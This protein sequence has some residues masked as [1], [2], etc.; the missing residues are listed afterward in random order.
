PDLTLRRGL[1]TFIELFSLVILALS[2][3][4]ADDLLRILFWA[5]FVIL[6]IDIASLAF[7]AFSDS[8]IGFKGIHG[9]KN[10]AGDFASDAFVIFVIGIVYRSVSRSRLIAIFSAAAAVF[11]LYISFSRTPLLA[12]LLAFVF[13]ALTR[14]AAMGKAL[15]RTVLPVLYA[16]ILGIL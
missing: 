2:I 9:H 10:A 13:V 7:P 8:P 3:R 4:N 12:I 6:L 11:L 16:L 14:L 1:R 5:S 15:G